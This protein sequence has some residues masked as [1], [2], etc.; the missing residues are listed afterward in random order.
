[1][2]RGKE[3]FA[4]VVDK[5]KGRNSR[6]RARLGETLHKRNVIG[7]HFIRTATIDDVDQGE[8]HRIYKAN[9]Q[10]MTEE[11]GRIVFDFLLQHMPTGLA[12]QL[13]TAGGKIVKESLLMYQGND[14]TCVIGVASKMYKNIVASIRQCG[15]GYSFSKDN[16]RREIRLYDGEPREYLNSLPLRPF[17]D[18]SRLMKESK[19][20]KF[21]E[22]GPLAP[23]IQMGLD[24]GLSERKA[25]AAALK[26][27]HVSKGRSKEGIKGSQR[28]L[29]NCALCH[30]R[31][32]TENRFKACAACKMVYYCCRECQ[33]TDWKVH[34]PFCKAHRV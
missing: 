31:E 14:A 26:Q 29:A 21:N 6:A 25:L 30:A 28:P 34:K 20:S 19:S 10:P 7:T 15:V 33:E 8:D 17:E 16:L 4:M 24:N 23:F 18:C 32:S 12:I 13:F 5:K 11:T 2:G 22:Q 3:R 9:N 27:Y 1:M